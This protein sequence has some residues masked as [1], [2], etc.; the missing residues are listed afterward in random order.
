M[1]GVITR[2]A[3]AGIIV[4]AFL[5]AI[6]ILLAYTV[7]DWYYENQPYGGALTMSIM[8]FGILILGLSIVY[9]WE[10]MKPISVKK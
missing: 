7:K 6:G 5:I 8:L 1:N 3:A 10:R 9:I 4:G 2:G